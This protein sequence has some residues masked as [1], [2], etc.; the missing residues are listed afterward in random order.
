MAT[1][2]IKG[3]KTIDQGNKNRSWL[4]TVSVYISKGGTPN[5]TKIQGES[6]QL[7]DALSG[8]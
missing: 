4:E 1:P 2:M 7:K 8:S 3:E 6:K 5:V